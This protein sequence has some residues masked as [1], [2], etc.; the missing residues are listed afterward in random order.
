MEAGNSAILIYS[1]FI[2]IVT[3]LLSFLSLRV[4]LRRS[5]RHAERFFENEEIAEF[6]LPGEVGN[7]RIC[8]GF[9][10]NCFASR[11]DGFF[12]EKSSSYGC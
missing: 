2:N 12:I 6:I 3:R 5:L 1:T 8:F 4:C 10:S 7:L 9:T 11:N